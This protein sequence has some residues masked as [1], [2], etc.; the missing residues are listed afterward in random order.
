MAAEI[1]PAVPEAIDTM[2]P[3]ELNAYDQRRINAVRVAELCQ[4]PSRKD[5]TDQVLMAAGKL[6]T[7][8]AWVERDQEAERAELAEL[9][10]QD[11]PDDGGDAA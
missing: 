2:T 3:A 4:W 1:P 7:D 6:V 8:P 5:R 11:P 9:D 10:A